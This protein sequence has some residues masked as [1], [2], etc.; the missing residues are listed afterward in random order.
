MKTVGLRCKIL[1]WFVL[2]RAVLRK[3]RTGLR[4]KLPGSNVLLDVGEVVLIY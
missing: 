1:N 2:K 3:L 4:M